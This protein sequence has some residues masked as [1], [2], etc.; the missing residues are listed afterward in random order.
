MVAAHHDSREL[1]VLYVSHTNG[2][3]NL[4]PLKSTAKDPDAWD[5]WV[6]YEGKRVR[7]FAY[8]GPGDCSER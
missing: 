4:R 6:E 7:R 1:Y 3:L 8:L 2:S 5:D